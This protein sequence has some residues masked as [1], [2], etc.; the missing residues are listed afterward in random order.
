[1]NRRVVFGFGARIVKRT[2]FDVTPRS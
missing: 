1:M 2:V